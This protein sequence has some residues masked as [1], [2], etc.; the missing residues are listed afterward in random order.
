[1]KEANKKSSAPSTL[2][3]KG[4]ETCQGFQNTNWSAVLSFL[5][6]SQIEKTS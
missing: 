6:I 5:Q 2:T 4:N 3:V 1:M